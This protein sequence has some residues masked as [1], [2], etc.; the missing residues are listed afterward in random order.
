MRSHQKY[1]RLKS[2]LQ[3]VEEQLS[4]NK[5]KHIMKIETE[6]IENIK[7]NPKYF[8]RYAKAKSVIRSNIG[9]LL[10]SKGDLTS[11]PKDMT[12]IL[13]KQYIG[14]FS[15]PEEVLDDIFSEPD[16]TDDKTF[17]DHIVINDEIVEKA[18]KE[19]VNG[20]VPGPDGICPECCERYPI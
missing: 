16:D 19:L 20:S 2:E 15:N 17:L 7:S 9:P 12:E 18:I 1:S 14:V 10:N 13:S 4:M 3:N 8:Y 6:A 5:E 11:H